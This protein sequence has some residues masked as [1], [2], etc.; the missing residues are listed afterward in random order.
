MSTWFGNRSDKFF[1]HRYVD[2]YEDAFSELGHVSAILEFGVYKG[3]SIRWLAERFPDARIVGGDIL[4]QR[5]DWPVSPRIEY[6]HVDQG[7]VEQLRE[8]FRRLDR[9]F[10]LIIEDGSHQLVHQRN[11]LVESISKVRDGGMYILEDIHTS[12][13]SHPNYGALHRE[14]LVGPL[15]FLLA[16]EHLKVAGLE[17]DDRTIQQLG[18]DSLFTPEDVALIFG[19]TQTV[20]V[21]KRA[22]L[23]HCCFY[24]GRSDFDY[25]KL[26][27]RCGADLYGEAES[28]S[29]I[30]RVSAS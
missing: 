11:C 17:L 19:K 22:T 5:P 9:T 26:C 21:Y 7:S 16:I 1:W 28:M 8:L 14:A 25:A 23:P 12:H 18:G 2:F 27:C 13:P 24:C 30:L 15:H 20:K 29:A 10:D 6:A 3:A 4:R